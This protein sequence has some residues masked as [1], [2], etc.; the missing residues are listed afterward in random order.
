MPSR[1]KYCKNFGN[2]KYSSLSHANAWVEAGLLQVRVS[3][4][5]SARSTPEIF[6]ISASTASLSPPAS[7]TIAA[8]LSAFKPNPMGSSRIS[9][10][11]GTYSCISLFRTARSTSG[12]SGITL[13]IIATV[14]MDQGPPNPHFGH[15]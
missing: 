12:D 7:F 8:T 6:W 9:R 4:T 2:K 13:R 3:S 14:P 10:T 15:V 1:T 11:D 5:I